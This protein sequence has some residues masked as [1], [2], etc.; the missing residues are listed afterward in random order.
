[1][2]YVYDMCNMK[3]VNLGPKDRSMCNY[4]DSNHFKGKEVCVENTQNNDFF[5]I[6]LTFQFLFF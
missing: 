4:F 5:N 6:G 2:I 1:M 3:D